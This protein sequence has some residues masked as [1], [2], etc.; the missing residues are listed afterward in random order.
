M[1]ALIFGANPNPITTE[2]VISLLQQEAVAI[3]EGRDNPLAFVCSVCGPVVEW[4]LVNLPRTGSGSPSST[5]NERML[6]HDLLG[7]INALADI[8]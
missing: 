2:Q 6:L 3:R 4:A 1:P 5:E 7:T 8:Y